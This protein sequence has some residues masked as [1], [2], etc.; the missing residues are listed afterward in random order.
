MAEHH[1]GD[2]PHNR[3]SLQHDREMSIPSQVSP[4]DEIDGEDDHSQRQ[5]H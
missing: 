3:I 2:T 4:P 5:A 1:S